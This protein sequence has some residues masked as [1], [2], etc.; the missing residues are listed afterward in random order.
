[1]CKFIT[2]KNYD[3]NKKLFNINLGLILWPGT[4][5]T[6][7]WLVLKY[8]NKFVEIN[9][10][11]MAVPI[12]LFSRSFGITVNKRRSNDAELFLCSLDNEICMANQH[13]FHVF[14]IEKRK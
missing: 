8:L 2:D 6:Q 4:I 12:G 13:S 9:N 7:H 10:E 14:R 5:L 1:V 3:L 11:E